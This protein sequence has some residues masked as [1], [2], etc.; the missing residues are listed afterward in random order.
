MRRLHLATRV[1]IANSALLTLTILAT[2]ISLLYNATTAAQDQAQASAEQLAE[3]ISYKFADIGEISLTNV[4][5]TVDATLD[6][7]MTAQARIAAHLT[8]AAEAANYDVDIVNDILTSITDETVLDE[9]WITDQEGFSYLTNV[10]GSDGLPV[11]FRFDPDPAVQ[12][13]ASKFWTLLDAPLDGMEVIT[14]PAQVREIDNSVYKYVGVGGTDHSRIVQVGNELDFGDQEI[15][16]STFTSQRTDVSAIIE[17]ILGKHMRAEAV[18][19]D[20]FVGAAEAA[21]WSVDVINDRIRLI[22]ATTNIGEIRVLD[23]G[24]VLTYTSVES[25]EA[26]S[27]MPYPEDI[28]LLA[29]G[30]N[31]VVDHATEPHAVDG[32]AYKYVS[33]LGRDNARVVQVGVPIESSSGNILYAVYQ[34]EADIL[35]SSGNPHAIW[36]VNLERDV[37]ARAFVDGQSEEE[38]DAL[39]RSFGDR[40]RALLDSIAA[41]GTVITTDL[42]LLSREDRGIWVAAPFITTGGIQIGGIVFFVNLDSIAQ[43]VY[44]EAR[45]TAIIALLLLAFTAVATFFGVRLLTRPIE[46][47]AAAARDVELGNQ[48]NQEAMAPVI[49]RTDEIGSLATVFLDMSVQVFNREEHLETLVSERTKELRKTLQQLS[50][51]HDAIRKDLEMAK[52]VQSALVREGNVDLRTFL[53]SSRMT[54]AQRVGGDFVDFLEPSDGT[55]FIT[56]GD[57]SG[58]G[59]AAAL[60]MA[61]SQAAIKFAVAERIETISAIAEEANRRLCSQNPM[62]LFVTCILAMVDLKHGTIDYVSAGHE[63]PFVIHTDNKLRSL[64]LTGG[65]AMGLMDDFPYSSNSITLEP[66]ETLFLYTDGL[67]DMV[68]LDGDLYGKERLE[69]SL[70]FVSMQMPEDIVNHVWTDIGSFSVGTAPADDMTC[71]VLHRKEHPDHA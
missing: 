65:L 31:R 67:T 36:V 54:P 47:I 13:Q 24:G 60:F 28:D 29:G 35:I 45:Q 43:L 5:R 1:F 55:L 32:T 22:A 64:P 41:G 62:G 59:V 16:S 39:T 11:P 3:L 19:L 61:A 51:A 44:S 34:E 10:L 20:R 17:G 40:A 25:S 46:T 53:A 6:D 58:K 48:P 68:N 38:I 63:S 42:G 8:E 23:N 56:I 18:I 2:S 14:Q 37:A 12:P 26:A 30:G 52:Q 71:L 27:T 9:F 4:I 66:G 33:I 15:L 7:P 49:R 21:D 70:D 57:V 69:K 50:R